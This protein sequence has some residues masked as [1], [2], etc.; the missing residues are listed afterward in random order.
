[1]RGCWFGLCEFL[2]TS[3]FMTRE[4]LYLSGSVVNHERLPCA[5]VA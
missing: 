3:K 5:G 2:A 4:L 1:M